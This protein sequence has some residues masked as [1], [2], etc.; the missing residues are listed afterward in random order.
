[1]S[2]VAELLKEDIRLPSPPAIAMQILEIVQRDDF[3]LSQLS[4]IIQSDPALAARILRRV[5]SGFYSLSKTVGS[6]DTAVA[7]LGVNAV[8]NIALSFTIP[9]VFKGQRVDCFDFDHFWRRSAVAAVAADLISKT[10]KFRND[11]TFIAALFQDVGIAAMFLCRKDDYQRVLEEKAI[12]GLPVT[13]VEKRVFGFDHQ[14]VGARLL[15]E[16]G[17]PESIYRPIRY[18]HGTSIV[19]AELKTVCSILHIS[20]RISAVYCG[21]SSVKHVRSAKE[22]LAITFGL[23]E[24]RANTLVDAV[25]EQALDLLAQLEIDPANIEPFSQILEQ[26]QHELSRLNM[27]YEMLVLEYKQAKDKSERFA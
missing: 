20:D 5:N 15:K 6:I 23:S 22:M 21:S 12:T 8:K 4:A 11:E 14:E 1:M 3:S 26:A 10:I 25:A 7:V 19:P 9:E 13:E 17:L 18:H 2:T 24:A 27:S 16:W